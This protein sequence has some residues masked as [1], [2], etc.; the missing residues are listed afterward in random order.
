[1]TVAATVVFSPDKFIDA[2]RAAD[3]TPA[4]LAEELGASHEAVARWMG[5][6]A[7]PKQGYA[8]QA[9]RILGIDVDDLYVEE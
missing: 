9:A 7:S 8:H 3:Y 2:L 6:V 4:E 5:G 1:M